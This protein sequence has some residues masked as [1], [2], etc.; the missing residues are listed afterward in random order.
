M[1]QPWRRDLVRRPAVALARAADRAS[2]R[3]RLRALRPL[4]V[5]ALFFAAAA[6]L[7]VAHVSARLRELELGYAL[8]RAVSE[9]AALAE[10]RRRLRIEVASLRSPDRVIPQSREQLRLAPPEPAQL[11]REVH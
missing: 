11:R 3:D 2:L 7:G 4:L 1:T 10:E 6:A 9:Q 5:A 8:S